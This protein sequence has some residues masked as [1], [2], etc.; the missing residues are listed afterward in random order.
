MFVNSALLVLV[1]NGN[2]YGFNF[3]DIILRIIPSLRSVNKTSIDNYPNDFNKTWFIT[4]GSKMI[5]LLIVGIV[6]PSLLNFLT[7]PLYS[8]LRKKAALSKKIQREMNEAY[9]PP[10]FELQGRYSFVLNII[11][12][13]MLFSSGIPVLIVFSFLVFLVM[14][15]IDTYYFLRYN[16]RPP[17]YSANL[18]RNILKIL[19]LSIILHVAFG[20][21]IYGS[22][23]IIPYVNIIE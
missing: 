17:V 4:V 15:I 10:A 3:N 22:N 14:Y 7:I 20:I 5:N 19:P 23:Q 18:H 12:V 11:F 1:L 8:W 13:T 21:W 2:I 16:S 6:S 9:L